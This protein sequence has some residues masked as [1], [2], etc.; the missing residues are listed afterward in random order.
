M[1]TAVPSLPA[2]S[3]S[4]KLIRGAMIVLWVLAAIAAGAGVG[5]LIITNRPVVS[6][7]PGLPVAKSSVSFAEVAAPALVSS[8]TTTAA[9]LKVV[10]QDDVDQ[11]QIG[12]F[13]PIVPAANLQPSDGP[14]ALQPGF[15]KYGPGQ[16]GNG[17]DPVVIR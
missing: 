14:D 8:K 17:T 13:W 1:T 9:D 12:D 10:P 7:A 16:G 11:S 3:I 4:P 15:T 5:A 6:S 2:R